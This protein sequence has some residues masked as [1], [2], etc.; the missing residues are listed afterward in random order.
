MRRAGAR[1]WWYG[2]TRDTGEDA[3]LVACR[4]MHQFAGMLRQRY[5]FRAVV[6]QPQINLSAPGGKELGR[7]RVKTVLDCARKE[8]LYTVDTYDTFAAAGVDRDVKSFYRI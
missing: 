2:D 8:G 3:D 6:A 7:P 4:L 5:I 1:N